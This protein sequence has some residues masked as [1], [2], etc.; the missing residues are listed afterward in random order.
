MQLRFLSLLFV[1]LLVT[2]ANAQQSQPS[3]TLQPSWAKLP[4]E[5]ESATHAFPPQLRSELARIRDAA[6]Q[7]DY[8]YKELEYLTD[9]IGPRTEGSAQADAAVHYVA[10]EL[11]KLGLDVHLEPVLVPQFLR[12]ND[13]AQLVEYPGQVSGATQKIV[14][15]ALYGNAPTP[16]GGITG[17]VVVVHDYDELK[18]LGREKVA[19]RIV[20]FAAHFDSRQ[21]LAGHAGDAYENAVTYRGVGAVAA[22]NLGAIASLVRSAGDGA[23]RLPHAGWSVETRIPAAALA[24]EDA[25]L[26]ERLAAK[27]PVKIHLSLPT[28]VGPEV[29]SYNVVADIKGSEHPEQVVIV[30]G[31]IDSWDLGTGA[32]DDGAGVVIAMETAELLHRLNLHPKRTLRVIA[33]MNEE[34]G[35]TGST[36]YARDQSNDMENHFAAI[37][38]DL[39]AEHPLGFSAK[40]SAAAV[41]ELAPVQESL[42]PIGANLI[43]IVP[44]SPAT[45]IEPLA[46]KSVPA[47]AVWQN[48]LK[49]FTYHHTPADT[50]DKVVPEELRENAACMA[51]L[52]YALADMDGPVA[53]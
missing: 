16:E 47:F 44:E 6:M 31:H 18:A 11:R 17:E 15:T 10:D 29:Q 5:A 52:G 8:A 50:L 24:A 12:G 27:G 35:A 48:G 22:S 25:E 30:S 38:S 32:I 3:Q 49:Y 7:D 51:V 13:S 23:Y 43:Q 53:K 4:Q 42:R 45:D 1:P 40:I 39:G 34:T 14:L 41:Q 37:E 36:T 26:I 46:K 33:W 9:S 20:L 28:R 2:V 19:G 21:A